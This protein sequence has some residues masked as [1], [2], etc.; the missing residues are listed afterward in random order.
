MNR[1]LGNKS[2]HSDEQGLSLRVR[3][4]AAAATAA[5]RHL[6]AEG[7]GGLPGASDRLQTDPDTRS[8]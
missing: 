2:R 8:F 3:C 4:G 5:A 1:L 6:P 7:P